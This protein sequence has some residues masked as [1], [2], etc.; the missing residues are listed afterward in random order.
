MAETLVSLALATAGFLLVRPSLGGRE[1]GPGAAG[2]GR[3]A[4]CWVLKEQP[5]G[6]LSETMT[7][8]LRFQGRLPGMAW[9]GIPPADEPGLVSHVSGCGLVVC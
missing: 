9:C 8:S 5:V 3:I 2:G 4:P 6:C 1:R 7:W